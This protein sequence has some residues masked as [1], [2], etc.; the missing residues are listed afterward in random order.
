MNV[1]TAFLLFAMD[2]EDFV[3]VP[4]GYE[5]SSTA[6]V[7]LVM[8]LVWYDGSMPRPHQVIPPKSD[9][10]VY[11]NEDEV[12][13]VILTLYIDNLFLVGG[14]KLRFNNLKKNLMN[15]FEMTDVDDV[16]SSRQERHP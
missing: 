1:Q 4:P 16:E 10:C 13:F 5:R 7:L 9:P 14:K 15:R 11:I 2:E 12:D 6:G 8:K 3:K